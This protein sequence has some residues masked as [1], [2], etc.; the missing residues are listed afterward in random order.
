VPAFD[1]TVVKIPWTGTAVTDAGSY[2]LIATVDSECDPLGVTGEFVSFAAYKDFLGASNNIAHRN[3]QAVEVQADQTATFLFFLRGIPREEDWRRDRGFFRLEIGGRMPR[4]TVV[5]LRTARELPGVR[6]GAGVRIDGDDFE[7][8]SPVPL[9][10]RRFRLPAAARIPVTVEVQ[11]PEEHRWRGP[12]R[13]F[14]DQ[15]HD[16][17]H[18]GRVNFVIRPRPVS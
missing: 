2:C 3:V 7:V 10:L 17:D 18:L 9:V 16:D 13:L 11:I 5:T 8:T 1:N 15:F 14:A 6:P 4:N 12:I